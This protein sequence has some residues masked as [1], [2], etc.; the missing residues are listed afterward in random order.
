MFWV[1]QLVVVCENGEVQEEKAG[2]GVVKSHQDEK[3]GQEVVKS[4]QDGKAGQVVVKDHL[5][6]KVDQGAH[7]LNLVTNYLLILD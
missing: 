4:H 5:V 7:T 2:Q 1:S 6:E 3:A